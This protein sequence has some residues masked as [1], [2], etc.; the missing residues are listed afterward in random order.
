MGHFPSLSDFQCLNGTLGEGECFLEEFPPAR[1]GPLALVPS[2]L[3]SFLDA[4]RTP[5]YKA[6]ASEAPCI[7]W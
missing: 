4:V 5:S 7:D 6:T 2:G 3:P 1:S